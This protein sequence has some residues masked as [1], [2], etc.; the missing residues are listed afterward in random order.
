MLHEQRVVVA[1]RNPNP[2]ALNSVERALQCVALEAQIRIQPVL[3]Y[4]GYA[5]WMFVLEFVEDHVVC[6]GAEEP[7]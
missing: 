5:G 1:A 6:C 3:V 7:R 4:L 2:A